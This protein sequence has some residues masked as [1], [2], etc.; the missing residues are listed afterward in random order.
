MRLRLR[1]GLQ[2]VARV[3]APDASLW[4]ASAGL[5]LG[6]LEWKDADA[7]ATVL[8]GLAHEAREEPL[9]APALADAVAAAVGDQSAEWQPELLLETADRVAEVAPLV[10]L[11]LVRTAGERLHWREDAARRLRALREHPRPGVRAAARAVLTA[12]E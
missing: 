9:F 1:A 6:L 5:R 8:L 12:N 10:A 2:E 4:P 11:T 3:L 7:T